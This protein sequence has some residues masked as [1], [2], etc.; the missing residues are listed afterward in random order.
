MYE[1]TTPSNTLVNEDP[2]VVKIRAFHNKFETEHGDGFFPFF[3]D[4]QM[5]HRPEIF[6]HFEYTGNGIWVQYRLN[7]CPGITG[8]DGDVTKKQ[9]IKILRKYET[10]NVIKNHLYGDLITSSQIQD[11]M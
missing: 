1:E 4:Y 8:F 5:L 11:L 10:V 2:I 6:I 3:Q 7:K 9:I